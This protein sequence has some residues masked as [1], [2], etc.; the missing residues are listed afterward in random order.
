MTFSVLQNSYWWPNLL[1]PKGIWCCVGDGGGEAIVAIGVH[2][3]L[4]RNFVH[5][6]PWRYN[7][8]ME[9]TELGGAWARRLL[10]HSFLFVSYAWV[11]MHICMCVGTH[12]CMHACGGLRLMS[13]VILGFSSSLFFETESLKTQEFGDMVSLASQFALGIPFLCLPRLGYRESATPT[14]Q[15]IWGSD[16]ESSYMLTS[17]LAAEPSPQPPRCT[18]YILPFQSF[19][20]SSSFG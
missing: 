20:F 19:R 8:L 15:G 1:F 10:S 17:T 5:A 11:C 14:W 9:W 6:H 18:I 2:L 16:L 13:G 7:W 4:P 3:Q 12:M